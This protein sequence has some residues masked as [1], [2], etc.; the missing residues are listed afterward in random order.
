[1]HIHSQS[2]KLIKG[3]DVRQLSTAPAS[4][5]ELLNTL[6]LLYG[7]D[8]FEILY[9]DSLNNICPIS[10]D[11]DFQ[12]AILALSPDIRFQ[13]KDCRSL[14]QPFTDKTACLSNESDQDQIDFL[15]LI[16]SDEDSATI[17]NE[18]PLELSRSHLEVSKG[19]ILTISD[20]KYG[21]PMKSSNESFLKQSDISQ[22]RSIIQ[23]EI[24]KSMGNLVSSN[25]ESFKIVHY[26]VKCKGCGKK[27]ILGVRYRCSVCSN[28]NYCQICEQ[29]H[30]H[31]HPFLKY[32][33][34][35]DK[36]ALMRHENSSYDSMCSE[37]NILK[38][39]FMPFESL[40]C[41][42]R[43]NL[44][45]EPKVQRFS[46]LCLDGN[47]TTELTAHPAHSVDKQWLVK[48]I[49]RTRWNRGMTLK[50]IDSGKGDF[51][52]EIIQVP[53]LKPSEEGY[54]FMTYLLGTP[55]LSRSFC[56][57]TPGGIEFGKLNLNVS[58]KT[59]GF[60]ENLRI[61]IDR[62]VDPKR[63]KE[64]VDLYD[65]NIDLAILHIMNDL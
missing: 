47:N 12:S 3:D 6:T 33:L 28:F 11:Q 26:N 65:G 63:L 20:S 17:L 18:F 41:S 44:L 64:C 51:K 16:S 9:T 21:D 32:K 62:G 39:L 55:I 29:E 34:P 8:S 23:E 56:L 37:P 31:I 15:E 1:M 54:I 7:S 52:V 53:M 35:E 61:L 22:M 60:R 58:V 5:S 19:N 59:D 10:N 13:I 40:F 42:S 24:D 43:D 45:S 30:Y 4:Y 49:G 14:P 36:Y 2:F 57:I 27:P 25:I 46:M 38:E 48:N 50:I